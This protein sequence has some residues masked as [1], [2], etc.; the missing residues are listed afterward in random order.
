MPV[1]DPVLRKDR[2][3]NK[4][5]V[6]LLDDDVKLGRV[7]TVNIGKNNGFVEVYFT[8]G[9]LVVIVFDA[10]SDIVH[11]FDTPWEKK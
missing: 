4:L 2:E 10:K 5:L 9:D 6:E 3:M 7:A 11:S 1:L 8:R